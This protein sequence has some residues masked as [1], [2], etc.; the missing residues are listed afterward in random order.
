[1]LRCWRAICANLRTVT[2]AAPL[3]LTS[4]QQIGVGLMGETA[5]E[6]DSRCWR[7][8]S[9]GLSVPLNDALCVSQPGLDGTGR[10]VPLQ[11]LGWFSLPA[12][13]PTCVAVR[14]AE[15]FRPQ[16]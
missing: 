9:E 2:A 11:P 14:G 3:V 6:N 1:M 16:L 8:R 10:G 12:P 5:H 4:P 13:L 15:I 7:L